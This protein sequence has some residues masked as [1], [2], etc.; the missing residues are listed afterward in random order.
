VVGKLATAW[1]EFSEAAELAAKRSDDRV[2]FARVR[3][4]ALQARVPRLRIVAPPTAIAGLVV[5][6]DGDVVSSLVGDALPVDPGIHVVE[7]EARGRV[8]WHATVQILSESGTTD[9]P[10]PDLSP[11]S[12]EPLPT[13]PGSTSSP[14]P[15]E[16][17]PPAATP[18]QV[19]TTTSFP[20]AARS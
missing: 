13:P 1:V 4:A 18:A 16:P 19:P 8:P 20:A 11:A 15:P 9:V 2:D 14:K 17:T 7:A 5:R 3:A 12:V 10:I 6:R